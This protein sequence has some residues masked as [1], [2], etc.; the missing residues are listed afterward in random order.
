[1]LRITLLRF[2]RPTYCIR[3]SSKFLQGMVLYPLLLPV[4]ACIDSGEVSGEN[5][6]VEGSQV[7]EQLEA[8]EQLV[9]KDNIETRSQVRKLYA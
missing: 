7:D 4:T 5:G 2:L 9:Q 8:V 3:K 6:G 1:M